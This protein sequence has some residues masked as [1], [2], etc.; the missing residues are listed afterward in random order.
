MR[1]IRWIAD[2][3]NENTLTIIAVS[4]LGALLVYEIIMTIFIFMMK[5]KNTCLCNVVQ[6]N[7][8]RKWA[9]LLIG[10]LFAAFA[11]LNLTYARGVGFIPVALWSAATIMLPL[12][13]LFLLHLIEFLFMTINKCRCRCE[14]TRASSCD[15]N[16]QPEAI[17]AIAPV[18]EKIEPQ[19]EPKFEPK[20]S[21]PVKPVEKTIAEPMQPE[22]AMERFVT[23]APVS[24]P[25]EV[26]A[27][28]MPTTVQEVAPKPKPAP[29]P[30][31]TTPKEA[32]PKTPK[33]TG[34]VRTPKPKTAAT[35]KPKAEPKSLG[36]D[37]KI[38]KQREQ[39]SKNADADFNIVQPQKPVETTATKMSELQR[40]MEALRQTVNNREGGNTTTTMT[41]RTVTQTSSVKGSSRSVSELRVEQENLMKQYRTLQNKLEQMRYEQNEIEDDRAQVGYY[42]AVN[43]FERTGKTEHLSK[44][45]SRNKFDEEEVKAA[46]LGLKHAMTEL[47]SQ[48]DARDEN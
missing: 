46:L 28:A 33:P 32:T 30:K 16:K 37:E 6:I 25:V 27:F 20:K 38:E 2:L 45:P 11:F 5:K 40:R 34:T 41:S 12:A 47:Q 43:S 44:M 1:G 9:V 18:V 3:V 48:I 21:A 31:T 17:V 42:S 14:C 29:K 36:L 39:V 22:P 8:F 35:A 13:F 19:P 10:W 26:S 4:L 24:T 7:D 15:K 23:P